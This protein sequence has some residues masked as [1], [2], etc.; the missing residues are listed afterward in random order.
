MYEG[1]TARMKNLLN[2]MI[3]YE[4]HVFGLSYRIEGASK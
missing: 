3:F 4:E 2:R 1:E